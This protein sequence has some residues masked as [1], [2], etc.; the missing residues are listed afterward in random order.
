MNTHKGYSFIANPQSGQFTTFDPSIIWNV[1]NINNQGQILGLS[2]D[3]ESQ[4]QYYTTTFDF[5]SSTTTRLST[6]SGASGIYPHTI[7]NQGIIIGQFARRNPNIVGG[8][9]F[10]GF[11]G[12]AQEGIY[13][14][15][16]LVTGIPSGDHINEAYGITESGEIVVSTTNADSTSMGYFLLTPTSLGSECTSVNPSNRT[17]IDTKGRIIPNNINQFPTLSNS[18]IGNRANL[19]AGLERLAPHLMESQGVT[20]NSLPTN[21]VQNCP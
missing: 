10:F 20:P 4:S 19:N 7:N 11:V 18:Q 21:P 12:N 16:D 5:Q 13:D 9:E 14:L 1:V 2:Y 15:N 8:S 6:P 3:G 17:S